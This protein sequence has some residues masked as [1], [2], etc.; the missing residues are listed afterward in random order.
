MTERIKIRELIAK[1]VSSLMASDKFKILKP[2]RCKSCGHE[3]IF[4]RRI[5]QITGVSKAKQN[6]DDIHNFLAYHI[7][8]R[9]G[10]HYVFFKTHK[11]KFYV[12]SALCSKCGSTMVIFDIEITDDII[13]QMSKVTGAPIGKIKKNLD[14]IISQIDNQ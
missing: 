14:T 12:D 4:S 5:F 3:G 8:K 9:Y 6:T 11:N 10:I 7:K 1:E 13:A 2:I